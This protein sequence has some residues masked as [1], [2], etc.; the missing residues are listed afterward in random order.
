M[1]LEDL[2][3]K[4]YHKLNPND[5]MI[6][7]YI[8]ANKE[9]CSNLPIEV[10]ADKCNVSRSTIM[11]FAQKAG[12]AGFSEL[13]THLKWE[14]MELREVSEQI[15][16]TVCDV[17]VKSINHFKE[18]NYDNIC[19][20]LYESNRIFAYG[21]GIAQRSVCSEFK[22][23]MLSMNTIVEQIPG[24]G[25]L[26]KTLRLMNSN[27][28]VLIVSKSGDSS[29]IKE[30]IFLLK[31]RS[32][33]VISLTNYSNNTLAKMSDYNLFVSIEEMSLFEHSN[34]ESMTLLF[35]ILEILFLKY[36]EYSKKII[37]KT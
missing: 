26:L 5:L 27:D 33:K 15:V 16:E 12:L 29:F 4:N 14:L 20:I 22:R 23:M 36:V 18:L 11:R 19:K 31:S 24:E 9:E 1:K 30:V 17:H 25:E 32:V 37:D 34:Y 10:L 28:C 2:V 7:K 21:T 13:K 35:I 6:W 8:Y 3:S